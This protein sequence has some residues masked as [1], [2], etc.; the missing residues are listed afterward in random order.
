MNLKK[1]GLSVEQYEALLHEQ[2]GV[3]A[4]CREDGRGRNQFGRT[5]MP[6]DHDAMTG[7]VRGLLCDPCNR[8]AGF[9]RH[10]PARIRRLAEYLEE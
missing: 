5:S 7:A 2:G 10:D 9:L 8:A 4:V 6:V 1:Y 3:C